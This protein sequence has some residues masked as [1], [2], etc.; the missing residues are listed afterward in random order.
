MTKTT[1]APDA[2]LTERVSDLVEGYWST[3]VI[4]AAVRLAVP[5][6]L[7]PPKDAATLAHEVGAHAPSLHRLLR[8]MQT[9]GL[10]ESGECDRFALTD[11]G[12]L[13]RADA[14]G[15]MRGRVLFAS[16]MLWNQFA[17]LTD[18]V[19]TAERGAH[20]PPDFENLDAASLKVFQQAMAESSLKAAREAAQVYDFGRFARLL[21][22]GGGFGGVLAYL[23]DAFPGLK[24]DV[25]DLPMVG[26]GARAFLAGGGLADRAGFIGG[27]FFKAIPSGYDAYLF[28]YI[29][30][31]W[32][33][34]P[35]LSIL[36]ACRAAIGPDARVVILEQVVPDRLEPLFDHRAVI[37]ADLTMLTVGGKERTAAEYRALLGEAGFDLTAIVP[38]ASSFSVLEATPTR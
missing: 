11:A 20:A 30:H 28:K 38:T 32:A 9:L 1:S 6:R 19:R 33:D 3:Q 34:E 13:L 4:A 21:D 26:E 15:S 12:R 31:D 22:V 25:F 7:D 2:A 37:R 14:P 17:D 5:D 29:L 27:D 16:G 18:V 10:V 35:A 36:K 8:A 24:G 23:M